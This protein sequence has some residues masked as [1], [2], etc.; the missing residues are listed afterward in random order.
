MGAF[1]LLKDRY[2]VPACGR[3]NCRRQPEHSRPDYPDP[4]ALSRASRA[5]SGQ[6]T[7]DYRTSQ[8]LCIRVVM[9][10]LPCTMA[11]MYRLSGRIKYMIRYPR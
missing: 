2:L 10:R 7:C 8:G 1:P 5:M 9:S 6:L 3:L 11:M 4:H